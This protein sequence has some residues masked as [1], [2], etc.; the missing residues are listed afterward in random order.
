[1]EHARPRSRSLPPAASYLATSPSPSTAR[2]AATT[3]PPAAAPAA[4]PRSPF[5][6]SNIGSHGRSGDP[7]QIQICAA[8]GGERPHPPT[9]PAGASLPGCYGSAAPRGPVAIQ[10]RSYGGQ[11]RVRS[12]VV[13]T[14]P[15][16]DSSPAR[17]ST[18]P[19]PPVHGIHGQS[20][21]WQLV[22]SRRRRRPP[23]VPSSAAPRPRP[24][25]P[26]ATGVMRRSRFPL[27]KKRLRGEC[28]KC[29]SPGH[30][31]ADCR[32]PVR[33][34]SCRRSGHIAKE[35]RAVPTPHRTAAARMRPPS[36]TEAPPPRSMAARPGEAH[37][38]PARSTAVII[39][40]PETESAA[41]LLHS[42][43]LVLTA[44]E[45]RNDLTI[46][47]VARAIARDCN[48]PA[49]RFQVSK[50]WPGCFLVRFDMS[51]HR[52]QAMDTGV[53]SCRGIAFT[54]AP[55]Q[56]ASIRAVHRVW[57]Y[58]CR[59]AVEGVA[60]NFWTKDVMQD[61]LGSAVK[62][63]VLEY[64]SE[65]LDDAQVC[66][67]W[68]WACNPDD[69]P[70]ACDASFLTRLGAAPPMR[71]SLP[72]GTPR[73]EGY[74][75]TREPL[76]IHLDKT[77]D[78]AP[79]ERNTP[80]SRASGIPSPEVAL[81]DAHVP[82][83]RFDW[84]LG[85]EDASPRARHDAPDMQ[86]RLGP[87]RRDDRDDDD[88][89][90]GRGGCRPRR[91]WRDALLGRVGRGG[92]QRN[93]GGNN[94]N[95]RQQQRQGGGGSRR[96][97]DGAAQE[98]DDAAAEPATLLPAREE[99]RRPEPEQLQVV[100]L[101][102]EED[103][104]P[105]RFDPASFWRDLSRTDPVAIEIDAAQGWP[106]PVW[107]ALGD[108]LSSGQEA[109]LDHLPRVMG[110]TEGVVFFGPGVQLP[111][112]VASPGK[113]GAAPLLSGDRG[114]RTNHASQDVLDLLAAKFGEM[115]VDGATTFL[116]KVLNMLPPSVMGAIPPIGAPKPRAGRRKKQKGELLP[117]RRSSRKKSGALMSTG[118]SILVDSAGPPRAEVCRTATSFP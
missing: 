55:W 76:L 71:C 10:G 67:V 6:W 85:V 26:P 15:L 30:H 96:A 17:A 66:Y 111:G 117:S 46:D 12:M 98:L 56:Q 79:A 52:D 87:R 27:H 101:P 33:C 9:P 11:L 105:V 8:S 113:D 13:R 51:W 112:A 80:S 28:F 36:S 116:A 7:G 99:P 24:N 95:R 89:L 86:A 92:Q 62:V 69:I 65:A 103:M 70:R 2:S 77:K 25:S 90:P 88:D 100:A 14:G 50:L 83:E 60:L 43:A 31:V 109:G 19:A 57:R 4:A 108:H 97:E 29:L 102:M 91:P 38:R 47:L 41:Q 18:T 53:V 63:D 59:V 58:Y 84:K 16:L 39:C 82:T 40:T 72:D 93:G 106:S 107:Q 48:I 68:C 115:E 75:D 23:P 104:I 45:R 54:M 20:S 61:V 34:R 94:N 5:S 32:D 35:C 64:R 44:S 78:F 73:E 49:E 1:M 21:E 118:A 114:E 3:S 37:R 74:E 110:D 81:L 42:K 22:V